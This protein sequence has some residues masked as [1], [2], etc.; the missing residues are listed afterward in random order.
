MIPLYKSYNL[1]N[2]ETM[3]LETLFESINPWK[4]GS[5]REYFISLD[6]KM[7]NIRPVGS[8]NRNIPKLA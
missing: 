5:L 8:K 6:Q 2:S 3:C 1:E 4:K 7:K